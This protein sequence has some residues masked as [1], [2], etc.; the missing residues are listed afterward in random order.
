MTALAEVLLDLGWRITGSDTHG[1]AAI[2]H[3]RDRG[4]PIAIGHAPSNVPAGT[5][6]AVY[7]AAVDPSNVERQEA[8]RR[9]L[10]QWRYSEML[11]RLMA[12]RRGI[13]VA[14]T[15]G[16]ST[17]T[18]MVAAVL[19]QAETD[20]L[21]VVGAELC[22]WNS[23]GRGGGGEWF[24]AECCEYQQSFLDLCPTAV[25]ILNIEPD[26]FDCYDGVDSLI[27]AF[28]RFAA[29]VPPSGL[30]VARGDC[31]A[32]RR[33]VLEASAELQTFSLTEG[34]DWWAAD[35][36][37]RRGCYG[38]RVFFRGR[39]VT[40][41]R[42]Q[43]PGRHNVANAL[44]ATALCYWAG[45]RPTEVR[46][47]LGEFQGIRRRMEVLGSWRGVTLVSDYAHHPTE[48]R[49]SLAT[50]RQMFGDR[51]IWCVF[52]PHQVSRTKALFDEFS[53]SFSGADRVVV[54]QVFCAREGA[55]SQG[56]VTSAL[57][58]EAIRRRGAEVA[59]V[60]TVAEIVGLLESEL[61]PGDVLIAMGAGDVDEVCDAF[62]R[63]LPR[64]R[65]AG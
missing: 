60:Y 64:H 61:C 42:L 34:A 6:L 8:A 43:V 62:T 28:G 19:E 31:Q 41:V 33:A 53:E 17:T 32:T 16:K 30:V 65:R 18:A 46:E 26:H 14:G 3:L 27:E 24:V 36:R 47:G 4:V 50:A 39:F 38:F 11:G 48:V 29:R 49:A 15:H 22:Q 21:A 63:R 2:D 25:A 37:E 20:P 40:E 10:P 13:G 54:A 44:A 56:L 9:G 23:S 7:S 58:G 59:D 51:R 57:L 52:Q 5:E 35:L 12:S 1:S 45:V 55:A